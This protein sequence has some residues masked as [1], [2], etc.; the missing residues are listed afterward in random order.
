MRVAIIPAAG[1]SERMKSR[2]SKQFLII[3]GRTILSY[4]LDVFQKY[5][6]IDRIILVVNEN[7][8][9]FCRRSIVEKH[10]F[11]KVTS[12]VAGGS[13]RQDS[14]MNG[15]NEIPPETTV[16]VVH[17]GAR[18]FVT[19]KMIEDSMEALKD[20]SGV[21]VG[22]FL[23]DTI[24][25]IN[26]KNEVLKT[27]DRNSLVSIQTPQIFFPEELMKAHQR[28]RM[29]GFYGTDD[30]LLVER[31]GGKIKV[32][33]GSYENIKITTPEDI[34]LAEAILKQRKT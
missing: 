25:E 18:P 24:K 3:D 12:V 9:D 26:E 21:A 19:S 32:V 11:N 13:E 5:E 6:K 10:Q 1:R 23:K 14:V 22:V 30:A 27:L 2:E 17:D 8:I 20:C 16:V 33:A 34:V 15:L 31:I 29:D 28:A 4:T 7:E